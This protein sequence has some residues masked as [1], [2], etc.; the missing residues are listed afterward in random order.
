MWYQD[1]AVYAQA[2]S[3]E[4]REDTHLYSCLPLLA[5][6]PVHTDTQHS[7]VSSLQVK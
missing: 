2:F 5:L 3:V 7:A 1:A 6:S 4:A